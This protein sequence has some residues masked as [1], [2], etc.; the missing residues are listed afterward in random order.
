MKEEWRACTR[1]AHDTHGAAIL[2]GVLLGKNK[3]GLSRGLLS[4]SSRACVRACKRAHGRRQVGG[5]AI[6]VRVRVRGVRSNQT[7]QPW[8]PACECAPA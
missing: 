6:L 4:A 7:R 3:A 8:E 2:Q 1:Q 5:G